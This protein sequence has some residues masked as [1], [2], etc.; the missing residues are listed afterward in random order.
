MQ[1]HAETPYQ[2]PLS[3]TPP[4]KTPHLPGPGSEPKLTL[5]VAIML[6][7]TS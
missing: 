3:K 4:A 5:R 2:R 6:L 1:K 7:Q